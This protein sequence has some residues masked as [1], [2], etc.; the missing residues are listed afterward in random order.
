ML[1]NMEPFLILE[2]ILG[3]FHCCHKW[4]FKPSKLLSLHYQVK[5]MYDNLEREEVKNYN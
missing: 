5:E 1:A 3:R 2:H 4:S